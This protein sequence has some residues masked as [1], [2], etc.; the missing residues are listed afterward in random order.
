[1]SYNHIN[2]TFKER[3][4]LKKLLIA[5]LLS[6]MLVGC[7]QVSEEDFLAASSDFYTQMFMD[8]EQSEQVNEMFETYTDEYKSFE[9]DELYKT[10]I[11][12]YEGFENGTAVDHQLTAM[13]LL[14]EQ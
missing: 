13:K 7:N 3:M 5:V 9:N 2:K 14:N 8:G 1:M 12:M 4:E 6:T 10:L 11:A